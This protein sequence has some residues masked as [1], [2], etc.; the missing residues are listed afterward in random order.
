MEIE[1]KLLLDPADNGKLARHP[2]LAAHAR[3]PKRQAH[4]IAH[5]F[6]T[7]ELHLLRHG[8]GLRVRKEAGQWMQTMKGGGS[9]QGG[10]H[11]RH[12]WE[13][14]VARAWPQLGKLRKLVG[15]DAHWRAV[16][17]APELKD[18]LQE[19]FSVEV[20]RSAWDLEYDG[21]QVELVLDRGRIGRQG[22]HVVVNEI[23]L[24][25]KAGQ[26]G[27]LFALA[28]VLLETLPLQL[29]N[30]SKAELGY[31]LCRETGAVVASAELV[32]LCADATTGQALQAV[33]A[34]CLRHMQRNEAWVRDNDRDNGN[35]DGNGNGNGNDSAEGLHQLRVGIRRLRS[36]IKLFASWAPCP[37][38][39]QRDIAWLGTELGAARDWDVLAGAT[40]ARVPAAGNAPALTALRHAVRERARA[41]GRAAAL[42]MRSPR[43]TRLL[44]RLGQWMECLRMAGTIEPGRGNPLRQPVAGEAQRILARLHR[45]VLRRAAAVARG[46]TSPDTLHRLRIAG[47]R[48]RYALEFFQPLFRARSAQRYLRQLSA[49]QEEL[50][51]R[52]DLAVAVGML[53]QL[54]LSTSQHGDA[55]AFVRGYLLAQQELNPDGLRATAQALRTL[56]PPTAIAP[57]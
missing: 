24:E 15:G 29:S 32:D 4:L 16:L 2:L 38:A 57:D 27:S 8:A 42:A 12:E 3:A 18:R 25:L 19:L 7:T 50:G 23:E 44:L 48:A 5:Y 47:K 36:A 30:V 56:A 11:A 26:A 28:L 22:R 37:A 20:E 1:L 53:H 46:D 33:L 34:N 51:C 17:A 31:A 52:H 39:L 14:P 9:V 55:I 43:Y 21:S 13:G 45:A 54:D 41:Q 10:L 49:L 35:G 40:L 6:D